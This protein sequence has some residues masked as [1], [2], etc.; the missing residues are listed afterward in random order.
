MIRLRYADELVGVLVILALA[1][2]VGI[3]VQ[4][5]VLSQWFQTTYVL[6]IVLPEQGSA[7]LAPGA[8]VEMLG[9]RAGEVRRVVISPSEQMYAEV[10][11]EDQ[12]R[13]FIRH[14]SVAVIRKRFGVAGAAYVDISR[15]KGAVLNWELPVIQGVTERDPT[16]SIGTMID[17]VRE[18]VF[19]ILDDLAHTSHGVADLIDGIKRGQGDIGRLLTDDTLVAGAESAVGS[20]QDSLAKLDPIMAN[21]QGASLD[22]AQLA[23]NLKGHESAVPALLQRLDR[24]LASLQGV[25]QDL[26]KATQRLPQIARNVEGASANLPSL[27]TQTQ[28]T[29]H[30]L[31]VLIAQLRTS[32]LLGGGGGPAPVA[33][34]R[35]PPTELRP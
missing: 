32:W 34:T 33:P 21:L 24:L 20:V 6:R 7:G 28:Q 26:T 31:D 27:L 22:I 15:G 2:F 1:L 3:A 30:D 23:K 35:L 16:E 13:P 14:D 29:V 12:V 18:K 11:V 19:P 4:A 9:T 8:D 25:M 17:Q 5:G 10:V